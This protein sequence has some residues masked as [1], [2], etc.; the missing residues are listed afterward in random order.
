MKFAFK[1]LLTVGALLA[2]TPLAQARTRAAMFCEHYPRAVQT[3]EISGYSVDL[4]PCYGSLYAGGCNHY[5]SNHDSTM[6]FGYDTF[7]WIDSVWLH[8][9]DPQ[10]AG[11]CAREDGVWKQ[12][13]KCGSPG[14]EAVVTILYD[15]GTERR[16]LGNEDSPD[17]TEEVEIDGETWTI[18]GFDEAKED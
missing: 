16:N 10:T 11:I 17:V 12:V 8:C 1:H 2:L 3:Y 7:K 18:I 4:K 13:A 15:T 5:H 6:G 14:H 9:S